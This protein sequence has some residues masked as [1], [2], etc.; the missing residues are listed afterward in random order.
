MK[1]PR[2]SAASLNAIDLLLSLRNPIEDVA[3]DNGF[4]VSEFW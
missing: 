3:R 2:T 1:R 4:K